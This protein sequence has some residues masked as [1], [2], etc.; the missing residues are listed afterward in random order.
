MGR[1]SRPVGCSA[2]VALG[3]RATNPK[4]TVPI[5]SFRVKRV[6]RDH[7]VFST[8]F[9]FLQ[10]MAPRT[11]LGV[12][13]PN[14]IKKSKL[15][16]Y[17]RGFICGLAHTKISQ[18]K[19][20]ESLQ[21]SASTIQYTIKKKSLRNNRKTIYQSDRPPVLNKHNKYRILAIIHS[22]PFITYNQIHF[23]NRTTTSNST[24]LR[25]FKTSGYSHWRAQK[26]PK[27]KKKAY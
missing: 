10:Q 21:I 22:N 3:K 24:F 18:A 9:L 27:L 7:A 4:S 15:S 19:I 25:L 20:K 6:I 2:A 12:I 23:Q 8:Y 13:D 14:R 1:R 5:F 17:T 16:P 11:P 26:R